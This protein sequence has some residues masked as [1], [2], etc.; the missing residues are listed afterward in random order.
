L[1]VV[2]SSAWPLDPRGKGQA[3]RGPGDPSRDS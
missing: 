2:A 1:P 3:N